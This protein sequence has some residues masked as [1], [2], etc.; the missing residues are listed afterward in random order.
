MIL[1]SKQLVNFYFYVALV[2]LFSDC[3][4]AAKSQS[5]IN[6]QKTKILIFSKTLGYHHTSIPAAINAIQLLGDQNNMQVDTTTDAGKFNGD[7]LKQYKSIVFLSTSGNV[8]NDEQQKIFQKYIQSGG[9]FVGIHSATDTEYDWPWY[10]KLVGAYFN[11]HP[12]IQEAKVI[13]KDTVHIS[14][15]HLPVSWIRTDE[16]Y[17]FRDI[18]K[19]IKL[20]LVLDESSYEGGKNGLDHP[21]A[22]YHEYDGGR[23]FYTAGGHGAESYIDPLF[24]QHILGGIKYAIGDQ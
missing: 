12:K 19:N 14:T 4:P 24:L 2:L 5:S 11:T 16:W 20:L 23:A 8:L 15:K 22:W 1:P 9:G 7:T 10:G 21:I 3:T 18:N 13:I 17:N 6:T